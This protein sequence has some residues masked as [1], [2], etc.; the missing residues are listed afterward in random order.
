MFLTI[1]SGVKK[2][3]I[4]NNVSVT[5]GPQLQKRES[6]FEKNVLQDMRGKQRLRSGSEGGWWKERRKKKESFPTHTFSILSPLHLS[7]YERS[8]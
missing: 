7:K 1:K 2:K 5:K 3:I 8:Q 4:K 6:D